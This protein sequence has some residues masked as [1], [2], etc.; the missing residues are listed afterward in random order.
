M[1]L[2]VKYS[3]HQTVPALLDCALAASSVQLSCI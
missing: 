2:P 1:M 3:Y